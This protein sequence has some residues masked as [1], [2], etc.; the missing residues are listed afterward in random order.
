MF[1]IRSAMRSGKRKDERREEGA[2]ETM[3][4]V[5]S[6]RTIENRQI[7]RNLPVAFYS[8]SAFN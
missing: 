8:L 4:G 6:T 7:P 1:T 2:G 3:T 5:D